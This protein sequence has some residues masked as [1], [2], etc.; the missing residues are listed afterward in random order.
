MLIDTSGVYKAASL[1]PKPGCWG[2]KSSG[3]EG[4]GMERGK[5][6][7]E[8]GRKRREFKEKGKGMQGE[9]KVKERGEGK[10]K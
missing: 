10:G 9:K 1:H 3:E 8:E 4:K 7:S 2:R 6:G 5:K